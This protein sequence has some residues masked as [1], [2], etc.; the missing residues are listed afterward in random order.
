M[1]VGFTDIPPSSLLDQ[2]RPA[3]AAPGKTTL[4]S[5]K[6]TSAKASEESLKNLPAQDNSE[7]NFETAPLS[8][9][10]IFKEQIDYQTELYEK[11]NEEL[12]ALKKAREQGKASPQELSP[13]DLV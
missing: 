6:V 8:F 2:L 12:E 4:I 10:Q 11:A 9:A 3:G 1:A 5:V 13:K 7:S